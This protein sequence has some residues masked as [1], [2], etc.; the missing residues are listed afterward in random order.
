LSS[1]QRGFSERAQRKSGKGRID[2]MHS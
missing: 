1:G 2:L